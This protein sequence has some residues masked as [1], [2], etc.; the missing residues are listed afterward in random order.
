[1]DEFVDLGEEPGKYIIKK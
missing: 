1:V